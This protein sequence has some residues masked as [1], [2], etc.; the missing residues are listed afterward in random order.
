M[1]EIEIP[2]GDA[3][4]IEHLVF[5]YNGTLATDG[6]LNP[7]V[8]SRFEKLAMNASLHVITA[9]TFGLARDQLAGLPCKLTILPAGEQVQAKRNYVESLGVERVAGFGNGRNDE[10][11]LAAARIGVFLIGGEG[12]ATATF[13]VADIVCTDIADALDLFLNP[14]RLVATLRV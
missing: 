14:K 10:Q 1:I 4:E 2:G 6:M 13:R 7:A 12:G 11:M 8:R 5:D 3:L 9:D